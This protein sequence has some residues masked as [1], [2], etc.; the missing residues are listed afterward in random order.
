[1]KR[2]FFSVFVFTLFAGLFVLL[3]SC[4]GLMQNT[5]SATFS[6]SPEVLKA[7]I[8]NAST[9]SLQQNKYF[10]SN[11]ALITGARSEDDVEGIDDYP[12]NEDFNESEKIELKVSLLGKYPQSVT[13]LYSMQEL[14]ALYGSETTKGSSIDI[15]FDNIPIGTTVYAEATLAFV[16][17]HHDKEQK[18][19]AYKGT[20]DPVKISGGSNSLYLT[21]KPF[22][23]F[24]LK[25]YVEDDTVAA[26]ETDVEGY[27][28]VYFIDGSFDNYN[29]F[30]EDFYEFILEQQES[31]NLTD[32]EYN[33]SYDI[34]YDEEGVSIYRVYF[35]KKAVKPVEPV[36]IDYEIHTYLQKDNTTY[37]ETKTPDL[38][39]DI[40]A[41]YYTSALGSTSEDRW[42][43]DLKN[44]IIPRASQ[45][46]G[47][48][49]TYCGYEL[50]ENGE[51]AYIIKVYFK[52]VVEEPPV[53]DTAT[54]NIYIS[55]TYTEEDPDEE[56]KPEGK[57][58]GSIGNIRL[59]VGSVSE[60]Q[61]TVQ[62][63]EQ[64]EESEDDGSVY[65]KYTLK[66]TLAGSDEYSKTIEKEFTEYELLSGLAKVT[67]EKVPVGKITADAVIYNYFEEDDEKSYS[68]VTMPVAKGELEKEVIAGVNNVQIVMEVYDQEITSYIFKYY[69]EDEK[70]TASEYPGYTL[71]ENY[72]NEGMCTGEKDLYAK[73][74]QAIL[75]KTDE[76]NF[77]SDRV[78]KYLDT[79]GLLIWCLFYDKIDEPIEEPVIKEKEQ[80]FEVLYGYETIEGDGSQYET[81][82]KTSTM[83]ISYIPGD[84]DP[85]ELIES[86]IAAK[87]PDF[88]EAGEKAGFVYDKYIHSGSAIV[89]TYSRI[90][91]VY[92]F[93]A[94]SGKF[95]DGK[96]TC[97]LSGKYE[98][99]IELTKVAEPEYEDYVVTDWVA[100]YYTT[101][102]GTK[103]D[104]TETLLE[105]PKTFGAYYRVL[106]TA[107]WAL[108]EIPEINV[109]YT[110][111][112][113]G[114]NVAGTAYTETLCEAVTGNG[115][116][117][118]SITPASKTFDGF[119][120][121]KAI[122][123][124][125]LSADGS[126]VIEIKYNRKT[127]TYTF[128][129]NNGN[130]LDSGTNS[131]VW[132]KTAS[133]LYGQTVSSIANP[134]R[135]NFQ[136]LGWA[137]TSSATQAEYA[138]GANIEFTVD[139]DTPDETSY[140]LYAVWTRS[141][142]HI[143]FQ[144]GEAEDGNNPISYDKRPGES[145]TGPRYN[146]AYHTF[147]GWEYTINGETKSTN[148]I[149]Y[150]VENSD[151]TLVA[152]WQE[153]GKTPNVVFSTAP[154]GTAEYV[155]VDYNTQIT[156]S[157]SGNGSGNAYIYYTTDGTNPSESSTAIVYN[158]SNPI[159]ITVDTVIKAYAVNETDNLY[160]S[161]VT[162]VSYKIKEGTV[163]GVSAT[164]ELWDDGSATAN[165]IL[166]KLTVNSTN[167]TYTITASSD[168]KVYTSYLWFINGV[169]VKDGDTPITTSSITQSYAD[170]GRT[171]SDYYK[172][173][174]V[175]TTEDGDSD[176]VTYKLHV[177]SDW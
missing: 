20:S 127:I 8:D 125:V 99:D 24:R 118:N 80:S 29:N 105:L 114:Q 138:S 176:D 67:V 21:L 96:S 139:S 33:G 111:K 51:N 172:I 14:D 34:S 174:C 151:V 112:Y 128:H 79:D 3:S 30:E 168:D 37:D 154:S 73:M 95:A 46:S 103:P 117:G 157:C 82:E 153:N 2:R 35:E 159:V 6:I 13:K 107:E 155:E 87:V 136:F 41:Y 104:K 175:A 163:S 32:Y 61:E 130:W 16:F 44:D 1:M 71:D 54:V 164:F 38:Q 68:A 11:A 48:N 101:E 122:E 143:L 50:V 63:S 160:D 5:G 144:P 22:H 27:K 28:Y 74:A 52:S 31:L 70:A 77:N 56:V 43:S 109:D 148:G 53:D 158:S 149:S 93:N 119:T 75:I 132:E 85:T 89:I 106:L 142:Y 55:V 169:L 23:L 57:E 121:E 49:Y 42:E 134:S 91:P 131:Y 124:V 84:S 170:Y 64:E 173:Y 40:F 152:K 102:K 81:A 147:I 146:Y 66:L 150:T 18:E 100:E 171:T 137:R 69:F 115:V 72:K 113:I 45:N 10:L 123:P 133:G 120:I 62:E 86:K 58:N 83:T 4:S 167:D 94:G 97:S 145:V 59:N 140:D 90:R 165:E 129:S 7:A 47:T 116:A 9:N 98:A 156:L 65:E 19:L 108:A 12:E 36:F 76:Y 126:N 166:L 25:I 88:A 177:G 162:S 15:T 26:T 78:V 60:E 161:D 92:V 110:I 39:K 17:N 135:N 141:A